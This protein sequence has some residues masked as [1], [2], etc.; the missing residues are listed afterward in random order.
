MRRWS[1]APCWLIALAAASPAAAA[2]E[3][4]LDPAHWEIA[5]EEHAF[6]EHLGRPSLR[7]RGA[8][9]L[10]RGAT[11]TDGVLEFD[12]ALEPERTFAG[13]MWRVQGPDDYENFYLRPHQSGNPDANQ[14]Q[15]V[16]HGVAAWQ[17]YHGPRYGAPTRYRFGEWTRVRIVVAGDRAEVFIDDLQ[18]PALH[19]DDL[20]RETA[21]GGVGLAAARFAPVHFSRFR[22]EPASSPPRLIGK[23]A[24]RPPSPPGAIGAW[25]VSDAFDWQL[26]E[27]VATLGAAQQ[28]RRWARLDAEADGLTNLARLQGTREGADTV[29]ARAVLRSDGERVVKLAFG[30]SDEVKV[31]LDGRLL[32]AG[33]DRYLSR[34]YRFLGSI[35]LFDE[36]YLPL[37]QGRNELWLAVREGFGGWGVMARLEPT[38]GVELAEP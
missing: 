29:F 38:P 28:P 33:S 18:T 25:Q 7:L 24:P 9:A 13:A 1:H 11:M 20:R 36:L 23:A 16:F 15:P 37:R 12:V 6:V 30:F 3:V 35:G 8:Q 19:V 10:A 4:P 2:A 32:Y 5:G 34:D 31:Y 21:A 22:F 26:L 17:L 14:Y 27:G